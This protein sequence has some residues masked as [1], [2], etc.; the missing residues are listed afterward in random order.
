MQLTN[1]IALIEFDNY[2]EANEYL[3]IGWKLLNVVTKDHG[4]PVE[5]HQWSVFTLG[6]DREHG[7]AAIY[8]VNEKSLGRIRDKAEKTRFD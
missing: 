1:I 5:R 6:W 7:D 3:E 4:H 2:K 8:P